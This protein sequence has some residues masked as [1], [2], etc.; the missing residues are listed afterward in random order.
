MPHEAVIAVVQVLC[1]VQDA[2]A[3]NKVT[4][5]GVVFDVAYNTL[6][7]LFPDGAAAGADGA[8]RG[9]VGEGGVVEVVGGGAK[10]VNFELLE[11]NLGEV[12]EEPVDHKGTFDGSLGVQDHDD[13]GVARVPEGLFDKVVGLA[14]VISVVTKVSLNEA[15][16]DVKED[17]GTMHPGALVSIGD[18]KKVAGVVG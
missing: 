13:F 4:L 15:L 6:I 9:D 11:E 1:E 2:P 18:I 16:D 17:A 7:W 8:P 12:G 3:R 14:G 10:G 5:V